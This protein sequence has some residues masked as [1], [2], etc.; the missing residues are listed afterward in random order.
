[1]CELFEHI[2]FVVLANC[3]IKKE[4]ASPLVRSGF[5]ALSPQ[6]SSPPRPSPSPSPHLSTPDMAA[7]LGM[8]EPFLGANQGQTQLEDMPIS[9]AVLFQVRPPP[10]MNHSAKLPQVMHTVPNS[11][12]TCWKSFNTHCCCLDPRRHDFLEMHWP[13]N[14]Q[15]FREKLSEEHR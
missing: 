15:K 5:S 14:A 12:M 10:G 9:E 2:P 6:I 7:D 11:V 8:P 4:S 3:A 1:M 13:G